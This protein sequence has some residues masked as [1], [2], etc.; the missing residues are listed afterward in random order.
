MKITNMQL[1][2][3]IQEELG[4]V[5][6]EFAPNP[7]GQPKTQQEY[8]NLINMLI[9]DT[10]R[11]VG[12]QND[13]Q[14]KLFFKKFFKSANLSKM[15][16]MAKQIKSKE[17]INENEDEEKLTFQQQKKLDDASDAFLIDYDNLE[18]STN[19][20]T[21]ALAGGGAFVSV[22]A[23]YLYKG[24]IM[25]LVAGAG[26]GIAGY[27]LGLIV[28]SL[29]FKFREMEYNAAKAQI[30]KEI[31]KQNQHKNQKLLFKALKKKAEGNTQMMD[32]FKPSKKLK[33]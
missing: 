32:L 4:N 23:S 2:S 33:R 8:N 6:N 20:I 27:L 14:F 25:S 10:A 28:F 26:G 18:K 1:R 3:I 22:V 7:D 29:R 13:T 17:Q 31:R 12:K 5:L 15:A 19:G 11:I 30:E 21:I 16:S 9:E 24:G